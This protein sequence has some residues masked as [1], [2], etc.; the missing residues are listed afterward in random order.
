MVVALAG[1]YSP[2]TPDCALAC[3]ASSDC[4]SGQACT[5]DHLC[6]AA[7]VTTCGS[8][9]ITDGSVP[10]SDAGSNAPTMVS[11]MIHLDRDG[12]V[13]LSTNQNCTSPTNTPMDC[14]FQVAS[15]VALTLTALPS[16]GQQFDK[17]MGPACMGQ[18]YVCHTTPTADIAVSVKFK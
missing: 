4:I 1:C 5:T 17:W 3:T 12:S 6:A 14:V 11:V 10:G 13:R 7:G 16:S 2:E 9:A 18:G 15:G 8:M